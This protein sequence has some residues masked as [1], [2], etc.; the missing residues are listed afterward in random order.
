MKPTPL[1]PASCGSWWWLLV[2]ILVLP[3]TNC[4]GGGSNNPSPSVIVV[5]PAVPP[6]VAGWQWQASNGVGANPGAVESFSFAFPSTD[7]AHYLVKPWGGSVASISLDYTIETTGSPVFTALNAGA[8]EPS[9]AMVTLYFQKSGDN[10]LDPFGRWW[11]RGARGQLAAGSYTITAPIADADKWSSVYGQV[12]AGQLAIAASA[13]GTVG[14]TFGGM[15]F[16][17]GVIVT[18]GTAVMQINRF[19]VN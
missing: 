18:G 19:T 15:F 8:P 13:V 1:P 16:G 9:T 4:G 6:V 2:P 12:D 14:M 3:L 11:A 17:H 7:G 5:A 10:G